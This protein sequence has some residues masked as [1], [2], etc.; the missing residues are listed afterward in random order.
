[1][2]GEWFAISDW[3]MAMASGRQPALNLALRAD[4]QL[5]RSDETMSDVPVKLDTHAL[6]CEGAGR[7]YTFGVA[8]ELAT[9]QRDDDARSICFTTP[10]LD[11]DMI[12]FG[13]PH[14]DLTLQLPPGTKR[15]AVTVRLCA[16]SPGGRS[17]RLSFGA[18]NLL[19]YGSNDH[20]MVTELP[21]D[22]GLVGIRVKLNFTAAK[23]P[24]GFAI[25]VAFGTNYWPIF[26]PCPNISGPELLAGPESNLILPLAPPSLTPCTPPANCDI[27]APDQV[28]VLAKPRRNRLVGFDTEGRKELAY[29]EDG[30]CFQFK[31]GNMYQEIARESYCVRATGEPTT[32]AAEF[33]AEKKFGDAVLG[34]YASTIIT[35]S[36]TNM[37]HGDYRIKTKLAA[38][39][40]CGAEKRRFFL[41]TW[42]ERFRR[43]PKA[44]AGLSMD[45]RPMSPSRIH[46]KSPI[47]RAPGY[48]AT[49]D[50][51]QA[52]AFVKKHSNNDLKS[53]ASAIGTP[54]PFVAENF[55]SEAKLA[56]LA[57]YRMGNAAFR[58]QSSEGAKGELSSLHANTGGSAEGVVSYI[59][60]LE[61][62]VRILTEQLEAAQTELERSR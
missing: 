4:R 33:K 2:N 11:E 50:E 34:W 16:V 39:E 56:E 6:G 5:V 25:R 8:P 58:L 17:I 31:D 38:F 45:A 47:F 28:T 12:L 9:D 22:G 54:L 40:G 51:E 32:A 14:L 20:S 57:A 37:C 44:A 19:H 3:N 29:V 27:L 46:S 30:G 18:S 48:F 26:W 62:K 41:K 60:S 15:G 49:A 24:K 36:V 10:P 59:A 23:V 61:T 7:W 42:D 55:N 21:Q 35:V 1:M 52:P 13:V 53:I 43:D